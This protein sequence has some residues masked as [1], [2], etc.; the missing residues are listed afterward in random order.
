MQ[1]HTTCAKIKHMP[2]MVLMLILRGRKFYLKI[3]VVNSRKDDSF[4]DGFLDSHLNTHYSSSLKVAWFINENGLLSSSLQVYLMLLYKFLVHYH[5][6][7]SCLLLLS[8]RMFK[9][10]LLDYD[11]YISKSK[12]SHDNVKGVENILEFATPVKSSTRNFLCPSK[13]CINRYF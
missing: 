10:E 13:L 8:L 5:E 1:G 6:N 2:T 3:V 7:P 12:W 9:L 11:L 4:D